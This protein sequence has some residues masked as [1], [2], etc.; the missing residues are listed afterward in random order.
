VPGPTPQPL[1]TATPDQ[2]WGSHASRRTPRY[3]TYAKANVTV[4]NAIVATTPSSV[5]GSQPATS[6]T[7]TRTACPR[8][9]S[10]AGARRV[11]VTSFAFYPA[12]FACEVSVSIDWA[13][14]SV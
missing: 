3:C 11:L 2:S 14:L 4:V 1:T 9:A 6:T 10:Y 8:S 12:T 13:L 7:A 5:S